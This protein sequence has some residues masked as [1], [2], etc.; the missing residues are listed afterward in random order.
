M[1][2]PTARISV[3]VPTFNRVDYLAEAIA[4]VLHQDYPDFE[5]VVADNASTDATPELVAELS[6]NRVRYVRRPRNCGW[7]V[8]FNQSLHEIRSEYTLML[9]DDDRLLPGSLTRAI[10]VLDNQPRVGLVHSTFHVIDERGTVV[11][12]DGNWTGRTAEDRI[13]RGREFVRRSLLSSNQV[14][15]STA[16]MRTSAMPEECF[17]AVDGAYGD[18][19]L[20]LRI[21][22]GWD[23]GFLAT[24]G[25]EFRLHAGRVSNSL[26]PVDS[27]L[28][29]EASKLRIIAENADRLAP[30]T[31]LQREARRRARRR[32]IM[33]VLVAANTSRAHG[34]RLLGRVVRTRPR[35][36]LTPSLWRACVKLVLGPR[37]L[38]KLRDRGPA[39]TGTMDA[40]DL[41]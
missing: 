35:I 33:L 28:V 27:I 1:T 31:P 36:A 3:I 11:A 13:E 18:V 21:A 17:E 29:V 41:P 4:S 39:G 32:L 5:L 37:I 20:Y 7:R 22:L 24:P 14:Y 19:V 40:R 12:S 2:I 8:N 15:F 30:V 9:C 23:V 38:A 26:D 25:A 6:D 16:V 34:V 10:R